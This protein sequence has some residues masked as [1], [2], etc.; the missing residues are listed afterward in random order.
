MYILAYL[1]RVSFTLDFNN[2]II[3]VFP[4]FCFAYTIR[5]FFIIE[6]NSL[7]HYADH[8]TRIKKIK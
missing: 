3:E 8:L 2:I 4:I 5:G 1:T 6:V 7:K